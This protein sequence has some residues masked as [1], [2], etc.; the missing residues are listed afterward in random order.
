LHGDV[1]SW[2]FI[3]HD[4]GVLLKDIDKRTGAEQDGVFL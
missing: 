4:L 3:S 1:I 2:S